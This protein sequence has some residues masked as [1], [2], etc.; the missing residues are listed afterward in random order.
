ML[1]LNSHTY[2]QATQANAQKKKYKARKHN[3]VCIKGIKTTFY[4]NLVVHNVR[5][6][7]RKLN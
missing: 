7:K 3:K 6:L 2:C 4:T 1:G 5:K